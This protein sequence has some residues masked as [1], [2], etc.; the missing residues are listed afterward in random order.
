MF[1]FSNISEFLDFDKTSAKTV[2]G[3]RTINASK[4][5]RNLRQKY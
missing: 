1:A 3:R 4:K 5:P 2:H